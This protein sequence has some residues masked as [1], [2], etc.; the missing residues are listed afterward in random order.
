MNEYGAKVLPSKRNPYAF[1]PNEINART[2][3]AYDHVREEDAVYSVFVTRDIDANEKINL[4]FIYKAKENTG[5]QRF[6]SILLKAVREDSVVAFEDER[7]TTP[8]DPQVILG[9]MSRQSYN[10]YDTIY[11]SSDP[12]NPDKQDMATVTPRQN[13][14][15]PKP[16][17]VYRFRI[18]E[19][20]FFDKE[21]SRMSVRIIGIAPLMK[22]ETKKVPGAVRNQQDNFIPLFWIY[23]PDLRTTLAKTFV[24]NPKNA[25]ARMSWD[26]LFESRYFSSFIVKSSLDNPGDQRIRD[27]VKDPMFQLYEGENIKNRI[28]DYE[29]SV[30]SY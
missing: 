29:Q 6:F 30:W 4:P 17:S 13:S 18:N 16:D 24:Y 14:S 10:E 22:L 12:N 11:S 21:T 26:D 25:G 27:Y 5:D 8:Y 2:P 15:A 28:F 3:L 20:W 1:V 9:K 7:F 19:Q 23:Y